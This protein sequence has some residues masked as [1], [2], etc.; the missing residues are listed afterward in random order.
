[1]LGLLPTF[2]QSNAASTSISAGLGAAA[3][4]Q[5]GHL[6]NNMMSNF[7]QR[8]TTHIHASLSLAATRLNSHVL[9]ASLTWH[10]CVKVSRFSRIQVVWAFFKVPHTTELVLTDVIKEEVRLR[11]WPRIGHKIRSAHVVCRSRCTDQ[12][13]QRRTF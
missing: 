13:T 4:R 9:R 10:Y 3:T 5:D 1:M 11:L 7:S 2:G 8:L 12:Q 6:S